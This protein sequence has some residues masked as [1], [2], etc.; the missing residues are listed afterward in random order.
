MRLNVEVNV[1]PA[2]YAFE[3]RDANG[4]SFGSDVLEKALEHMRED[5]YLMICVKVK[6][7]Q[8]IRYQLA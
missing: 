8:T 6:P 2:Q 5:M 7:T 4:I 1:N 3:V